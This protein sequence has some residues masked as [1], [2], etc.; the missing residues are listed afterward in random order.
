MYVNR[1]KYRISTALPPSGIQFARFAPQ[2]DQPAARHAP[3]HAEREL[4][5][6]YKAVKGEWAERM[7]EALHKVCFG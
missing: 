2:G 5:K 6:E 7:L 3:P 4:E 1:F